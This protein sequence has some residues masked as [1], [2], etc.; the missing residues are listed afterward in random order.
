M[1]DWTDLWMFALPALL[2]WLAAALLSLRDGWQKS[3]YGLT[4]GGL[5]IFGTYIALMLFWSCCSY[6][7]NLNWE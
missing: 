3:V 5:F 4:I 1:V 6:P 2:C 7:Y